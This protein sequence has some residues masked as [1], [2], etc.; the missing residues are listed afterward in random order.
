MVIAL[1]L[2]DKR[3]GDTLE[4]SYL[5]L[6]WKNK[7]ELFTPLLTLGSG[8]KKRI[9]PSSKERKVQHDGRQPQGTIVY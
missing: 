6:S 2:W 9:Y 1:G 5:T 4:K 7:Q 8:V 3:K